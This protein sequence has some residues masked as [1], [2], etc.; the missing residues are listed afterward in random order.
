MEPLGKSGSHQIAVDPWEW[1]AQ[2]RQLFTPR[3]TK[4]SQPRKQTG[5]GGFLSSLISELGGAGGAAGGAALGTAL[6]PGVGTLA[7]AVAG[8]FLGGA[9]GR[10]AENKVR[11]NQFNLG[12]ALKEGGLDAALSGLGTGYQVAKAAKGVPKIISAAAKESGAVAQPPARVGLLEG[13]GRGMKA[14]AMGFGQGAKLAGDR[15]GASQ[16]DQIAA[17]LKKLGIKAT[18]PE[19]AQRKVETNLGSLNNILSS[20]YAKNNVNLTRS[21][22]TALKKRI[23]EEVASTGGGTATANKY[24]QEQL[25]RLGKVKNTQGLWEFSKEL[26][27]NSTKFGV[28]GDSKLAA[29]EVAARI[30]R[31]GIKDFLNAKT[32]GLATNNNLYHE[33][34]NANELLKN[35]SA[36]IK[37]GG[38]VGKIST[39]SPVRAAEAKLG[40][41]LEKV[42]KISAGTGGALTKVTNQAKF[43]APAN[44]ASALSGTQQPSQDLSQSP[45][46]ADTSQYPS[47]TFDQSSGNPG[48]QQSQSPYPLAAALA[49]IQNDPKHISDYINLYKTVDA[50]TKSNIP[51]SNIGKVSSQNFS[52]AQSGF[53]ALQ[54]LGQLIQSDPTILSRENAPGRG[55]PLVGGYIANRANTTTYDA[56]AANVADKYIRLTTGA[57]ANA[58]EIKNLKSQMLPRPGDSPQQAQIKLQQ[59]ASLF[60]SIL[61]QAQGQNSSSGLSDVLSQLQT[62]GGY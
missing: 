21:E 8:G 45:D 15:I 49:D 43:Q 9:S 48:A 35:A 7:G 40:S 61:S 11:D 28:S 47:T 14:S 3:Q 20:S 6:L 27:R 41:G 51:G 58:D 1:A 32:P 57:T 44:L 59:F 46:V 12:S 31:N 42:G 10:L 38:L 22:M 54:Q 52:N 26:T 36:D 17:T 37:G 39:L 30:T 13:A 50:A 23:S 53:T 2:Q 18:S 24:A 33:V 34:S 55:L 19:N 16:S 4:K 62:Q 60:Q 29:N 56:L 25:T 5:K